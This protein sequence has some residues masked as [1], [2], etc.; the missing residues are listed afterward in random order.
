MENDLVTLGTIGA[1]HGVRGEVRVKPYTDDPL[2]LKAYSPLVTRDGRRL[3]VAA[4]RMAKTVVVCRLKGVETREAAEALKGVDLMVPRSRL[5]KP[6]EDEFY[7]EDLE[8]LRVLGPGGDE[9]GTV[10]AGHNFGAGDI[11]E[12]RLDGQR[13]TVMIPFDETAVPALDLDGG[14]L[15]VDPLAAGLIDAADEEAADGESADGEAAGGTGSATS[16]DR[17]PPGA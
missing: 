1:P 10:V 5:P 16:R 6:D 11:L 8:G 9:I 12:L 13:A 4:A 3:E 2:A 14:T 15:S 7:L 17:A